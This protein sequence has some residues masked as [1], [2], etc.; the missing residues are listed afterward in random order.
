MENEKQSISR[1]KF[2][3]IIGATLGASVIG[4]SYYQNWGPWD[5]LTKPHL[6]ENNFGSIEKNLFLI[7]KTYL[8]QEGALD[9]NSL[10]QKLKWIENELNNSKELYE[11]LKGKV[12]SDFENGAFVYLDKWILAATEAHLCG[13]YYLKFG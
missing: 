8:K 4:G 6:L 11:S 12:Q 5:L 2:F 10:T 13:Y 7:G 3:I 9:E 1:R